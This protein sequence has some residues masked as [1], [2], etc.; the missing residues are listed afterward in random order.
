MSFSRISII[1]VLAEASQ[2]I[3]SIIAQAE[4]LP[5]HF[6]VIRIFEN[7][8]KAIC[9]YYSPV[10]VYDLLVAWAGALL[11]YCGLLLHIISASYMKNI[12]F[13]WKLFL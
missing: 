3:N 13:P 1:T 9:D 5:A 2:G 7:W 6:M 11:A 4:L 12:L 10:L 8:P